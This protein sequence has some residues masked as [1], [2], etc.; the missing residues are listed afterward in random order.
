MWAQ[1]EAPFLDPFLHEYPTDPRC[2]FC[3]CSLVA[4]FGGIP[5]SVCE[6][7]RDDDELT[8]ANAEEMEEMVE[9]G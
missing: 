9:T 8:Y 1:E 5:S 3:G 2:E 6:S 7:C 4:R